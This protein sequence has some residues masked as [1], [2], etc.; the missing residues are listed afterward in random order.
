MARSESEVSKQPIADTLRTEL[1]SQTGRNS[2]AQ[3][4]KESI[5]A[6]QRAVH[7]DFAVDKEAGSVCYWVISVHDLEGHRDKN[8]CQLTG[9][10][11]LLIELAFQISSDGG[12]QP[13]KIGTQHRS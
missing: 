11:L 12:E 13:I 4:A 8:N 1:F 10:L 5:R 9:V 7:G 6:A 2:K 3:Q